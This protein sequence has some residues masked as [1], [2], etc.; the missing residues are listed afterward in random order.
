V[1]LGKTIASLK[2]DHGENYIPLTAKYV[3]DKHSFTVLDLTPTQ[4]DLR[5]INIDGQE[6]DRIRITK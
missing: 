3:A 5:Q 6:V 2:R 1:D 4:L